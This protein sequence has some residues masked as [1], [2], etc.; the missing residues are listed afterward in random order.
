[1]S[2]S[3]LDELTDKMSKVEGV[4][5]VGALE[6]LAWRILKVAKEKTPVD[7]GFLKSSGEVVE[8]SDGWMVR[9]TAK[10][11]LPVHERTEVNHPVGQAKFL[12]DAAEVVMTQE[13]VA[14]IIFERMF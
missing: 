2:V 9:F 11:A 14:E 13:A 1:M 7:T 4:D 6:E 5:V 10:Y 8:E 12:E 3:G